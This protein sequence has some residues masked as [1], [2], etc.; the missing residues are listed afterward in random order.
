MAFYTCKEYVEEMGYFSHFLTAQ[1]SPVKWAL[2][3]TIILPSVKL[4]METGPVSDTPHCK[5]APKIG[6]MFKRVVQHTAVHHN[7]TSFR[8]K[9]L[10]CLTLWRRNYFFL[11]STHPVYKM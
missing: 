8:P 6:A 4:K 2:R 11:I 10:S 5:E 3:N 1:T 9:Q 7:Q